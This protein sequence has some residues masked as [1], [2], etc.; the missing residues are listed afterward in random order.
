MKVIIFDA[1][2]LITFAMNGL[3]PEFKELKKI[4]NGKFIITKD[5]KREII[6]RPITIKRFELEALKLKQLLDEKIIEMPSCLGINED[7]ISKKTKEILNLANNIF[8]GKG[9]NI[10]LIQLGEASCLVLSRLLNEKKIE[11]VIAVD[12]RTTRMLGE[13]PENLERLLRKKLHTNITLKK[14]NF[15]FFKGFK[16]IRSSELVYVA[17]KKGLVKLKNGPVLDALLWAVKFKGCAISGDEINEIK[18]L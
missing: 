5:V 6:D 11:N 4:F 3:L 2:T 13:K 7:E 14:E 8:I 15:Y 17:Y 18:R 16:F 1:S 10:E 9:K 12:E